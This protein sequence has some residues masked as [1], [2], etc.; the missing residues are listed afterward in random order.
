M[1]SPVSGQLSPIFDDQFS[2]D[3]LLR[4]VQSQKFWKYHV[5]RLNPLE[6][7]IT[8]NPDNRHK[9][10]RRG[11][12]YYIQ[13][14]LPDASDTKGKGKPVSHTAKGFRM[15]FSQQQWN[16]TAASPSFSV[17]KLPESQG[18]TYIAKGFFNEHED[19]DKEIRNIEGKEQLQA[20]NWQFDRISAPIEYYGDEVTVENGYKIGSDLKVC[21]LKQKKKNYFFKN[22]IDG[23]KLAKEGATYFIDEKQLRKDCW[24]NPVVAVYRPC[25]REMT[26]KIVKKVVT[27]SSKLSNLTSNSS[28]KLRRNAGSASPRSESDTDDGDDDF[29]MEYTTYN[30]EN[31]RVKY[32]MCKDGIKDRH[33][34]DDSPNDYKLGWIT[35]YDKEGYFKQDTQ[36]GSNWEVVLGMTFAYGVQSSLDRIL[37]ESSI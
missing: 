6:F 5:M 12:S 18:G 3:Q 9:F 25:K 33:P 11:P 16:S 10:M 24:F 15:V 8:T 32:Y 21:T 29:R 27:S 36:R 34:E 22:K 20:L 37:R 28:V 14:Q 4:A 31:T 13:V 2:R 35:I 30:D 7:Y 19:G 23:V 17:E 1:Q 26:S